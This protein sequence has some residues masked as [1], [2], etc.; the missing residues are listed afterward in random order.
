MDNLGFTLTPD[1]MG[2]FRDARLPM[3]V[4]GILG[5]VGAGLYPVFL[6]FFIWALSK[7][8]WPNSGQESLAYLLKHS[9]RCSMLLF[10]AGTT[11]ALLAINAALNIIDTLLIV[12]LDR[13]SSQVAGLSLGQRL[14]AAFFQAAAS[15]HAGMTPYDL[16]KVSPAVQFSLLVMMYV[17]VLPI[18]LSIR[19]PNP[20]YEEQPVAIFAPETRYYDETR[21]GLYLLQHLRRQLSRDLWFIFLAIFC[22]SVSEARK[23][24]DESDAAFQLF[25]L[26]FEVVSAYNNVG[27]SLGAGPG[28]Y[29]ALS[30]RFSMAGKLVICACMIRGRHRSMPQR[31]DGAIM[32]P[33]EREDEAEK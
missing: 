19:T 30:T 20:S 4:L 8:K 24:K 23:L 28:I 6:R 26:F 15:R 13:D 2:H 18:A 16:A 21:S 27:I 25:P 12:I 5:L 32:L 10:P 29:S 22:L 1:S 9:R 31:L 17:S 33:G 3:V 14:A 7:L 11:H